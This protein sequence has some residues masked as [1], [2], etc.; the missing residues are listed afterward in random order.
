M[1]DERYAAAG[2]EALARYGELPGPLTADP[3][4]WYTSL[5]D[6]APV[7]PATLPDGRRVWVVTTADAAA[8]VFTDRRFS[9]DPAHRADVGAFDGHRHMGIADPPDHRRLRGVVAG[10]FAAPQIARLRSRVTEVVDDLLSGV[11]GDVDL[12]ADVAAVLPL[13]VMFGLFGV[14]DEEQDRYLAPLVAASNGDTGRLAR[15]RDDLAELVERRAAEPGDDVLST[16][17]RARDVDGTLSDGEVTATVFLLLSAGHE[18]VVSLVTVGVYTLLRHERQLKAL[19]EHTGLIPT[20]VEEILRFEPTA[21]HSTGRYAT[22]DVDLAGVTIPAGD[23]VLVN[24]AAVNRDPTL[25]E[26][27][28]RFDVTRESPRHHAFGRGRHLC[29]GAPLARLEAEIAL[30]RLL[31][32]Y[33]DIRP[34]AEGAA[35]RV[36]PGLRGLASFP[37]TVTR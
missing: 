9:N 1:M 25:N 3:H 16:L 24:L 30:T 6:G 7:H 32:T 33:R 34:G 13:R 8:S 2:L 11:D 5:R 14:P 19:R 35:W 17:V 21:S 37:V 4:R 20:A 18:T 12:V 29:L 10:H 27:P 36:E 22:Q 28:Q 15:V 31:A 23:L 26:D